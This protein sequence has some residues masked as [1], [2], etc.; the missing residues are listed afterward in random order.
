[1]TD[2]ISIYYQNCRGLR[3]KLHTLYIN[4]LSHAYDI[5]ILTETWLHADILDSEYIDS[6]YIIFR[7]D[8]DRIAT[9]KRDG[10]GVLVAVLR[11][12]TACALA[13]PATAAMAGTAHFAPILTPIVDTV[14]IKLCAG[15]ISYVI[16][17]VYLPP[18]QKSDVYSSY[19]N[20][21]LDLLEYNNL[22]TNKLLIIGD[23]NLSSL[24]WRESGNV[25]LPLLTNNLNI[26]NTELLNF[27]SLSNLSQL[28]NIKNKNNH[29]LDLCLTNDANCKL[30]TAPIFLVPIDD[31]HPP[32]IVNISFKN[33]TKFMPRTPH[34]ILDFKNADFELINE[35][36]MSIEWK[37]QFKNKSAS[38]AVASFYE[39]M[40][41]IIRLYVPTKTVKS[42]KYPCWFSRALI[43][44]FND[45]NKAWIKWKKYGSESDYRVFSMYR[46]RFKSECDKCYKTYMDNVEDSIRNSVKY[47][48]TYISNRKKCTD[49]PKNIIFKNE[50]SDNPKQICNMFS[51]YFESVFEPSSVSTTYDLPDISDNMDPL[52]TL[53]CDVHI[54][55]LDILTEL[56]LLDI[57]KGSGV[58][59][60]PPSFLKL[61]ANSIYV[62]LYILY[63]KCLH[64]GIFPDI[65]KSARIVPVHKSG[66][67]KD[68]ENYRPISILS[69]LS[70]LFEKLVHKLIYPHLHK[71]IIPQQHGFV[72]KRSTTS[73]LLLYTSFLFDNIDSNKQTDSIYTDFRKA[74][75]RVDHKIL[76]EKIAYNGIRGNL[77]RWFR[78]YI[79]NRTQTVVLNGFSSD[80]VNITSG[81]PQG[82]IL[83]PLLFV[84]FINDIYKCFRHCNFLLYADDL[85]IYREIINM[86][87]HIKIQED[88]NRFSIYCSSNKL[89][90]S[91]NKCKSITFTKK[92]YISN[93]HYSLCGTQINKVDSIKDLGITLDCKL[94]LDNHIENIVSK[95]YKMYGFVMRSSTLFKQSSTYIHLYKA[96]IRS[97]LE[98]AVPIW[99]PLYNKYHDMIESVQKKFLRSMQYKCHKNRLSYADL[100]LKYKLLDLKSRRLQLEA[101]TLYDLCRDKYDC[102]P[103]TDRILYRVPTNS[104]IRF[105]RTYHLF[106]TPFS[107]TNAGFRSPLTRIV[108]NYNDHF[109]NIDLFTSL[110]GSYRKNVIS[111]LLNPIT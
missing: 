59:N 18:S 110:P 111:T 78:S 11:T 81:V 34:Q 93:F 107:R 101:M 2:N 106:S 75:D 14:V 89:N 94:H 36:I 83:G 64:E 54:S 35:K 105:C 67:K 76:L 15:N 52:S 84:L 98:Y 58:D 92:R 24:E 104:H 55:D 47:F 10:G 73:N 74:F 44:I 42:S 57:T 28:N 86:D 5:I 46:K 19:Y 53:L 51:N 66:S 71:V 4:I 22:I 30:S 37:Q 102:I 13:L 7:S 50:N 95:A 61:T 38:D 16:S 85:K 21:L 69:A 96:L 1:M 26:P 63:N 23:F 49:I 68:V 9:G 33:N 88:L 6:R 60:I 48:W 27:M 29:I 90:L 40:Y 41:S 31:H 32:F 8:R 91:L 56:K 80:S 12:L 17:A 45:K 70:K 65:W 103:L 77:W 62:P 3:T 108:R 99:N 87:D 82:S 20:Y 25:L 79:T 100:L 109:N 39:S 72:K 97:Q 43:H